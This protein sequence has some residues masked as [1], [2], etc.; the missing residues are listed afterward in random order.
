MFYFL[1]NLDEKH[2]I[3]AL[4]SLDIY[5]DNPGEERVQ[6]TCYYTSRTSEILSTEKS[7]IL[8]KDI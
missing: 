8:R 6:T 3:Y 4:L 5:L 2:H 7:W 1:L